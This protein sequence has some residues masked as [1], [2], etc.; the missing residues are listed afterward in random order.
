[1]SLLL[2][3][4]HTRVAIVDPPYEL[5]CALGEEI[6]LWMSPP[7]YIHRFRQKKKILV[8]PMYL[9]KMNTPPVG[10]ILPACTV[11]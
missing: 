3:V 7:H 1:M 11:Y 9:L 2:V 8:S 6:F 4:L 5:L 10:T